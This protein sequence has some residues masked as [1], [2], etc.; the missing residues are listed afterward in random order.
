MTAYLNVK[1]AAVYTTLSERT[2]RYAIERG[3]L[4]TLR[5]GRRIVLRIADIDAWMG[6]NRIAT[7]R[8]L[9][10]AS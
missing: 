10:E 7:T 8:E 5:H 3:E 4:P 6:G 2:I 9:K 1:D